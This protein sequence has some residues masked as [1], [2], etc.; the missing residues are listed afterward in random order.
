[1]KT[2][3]RLIAGIFLLPV[4]SAVHALDICSISIGLEGC[5]AP[6]PG[7]TSTTYGCWDSAD[8]QACEASGGRGND[9]L[10]G[11]DG[12]DTLNGS[13]GNDTLYGGKGN[14]TL[15]GSWGDDILHGG[16]GNDTLNGSWGDDILYGGRGRDILNGSWGDDY[17]YGGSGRD[18]LNGSWGN[19]YMD[20][21]AGKDTLYGGWGDDWMLGGAGNDRMAG[22]WGNDFMKGGAGRDTYDIQGRGGT[23][24]GCFGDAAR[25]SRH[26]KNYDVIVADDK[27][28]IPGQFDNLTE[29]S[30][31]EV[32]LPTIQVGNHFYSV[33]ISV[34]EDVA[35]RVDGADIVY[36]RHPN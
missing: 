4:V 33:D 27:D 28:N 25:C 24:G 13:W 30:I 7:I 15:N 35:H 19:D 23:T 6:K 1:M 36:E 32:A 22:N 18:T 29:I 20:G 17:L 5:P 14:D 10:Y 34:F 3:I 21:G 11:G 12:N 8:Q 9:T 16:R 26:L 31:N 2:F